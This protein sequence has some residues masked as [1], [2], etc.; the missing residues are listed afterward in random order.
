MQPPPLDAA[1]A[2][3]DNTVATPAAAA[4]LSKKL[5]PDKRPSFTANRYEAIKDA[6]KSPDA[7]KLT[8]DK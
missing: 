6:G 1:A 3:A 8:K 2:A 7:N 4:A 5:I